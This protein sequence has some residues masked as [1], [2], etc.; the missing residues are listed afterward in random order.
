MNKFYVTT[1]IAYANAKPHIGFALEL[2]QADVLARLHRQKGENTFFLTGTDEHGTKLYRAAKEA[3]KEPQEFCDEISQQYRELKKVLN[4]SRDDFIRTTEE[5]H[6]KAAQALWKKCEKDI[7]KK[8]YKGYYCVGC[9]NFINQKDLVDGKCPNH[10]KKPELV[11]EENYFFKLSKYQDKLLDFYKE[12]PNF[13]IPEKRFNEIRS[14]VK[15]GLEDISI[16]RSKE[17]LPWGIAVP[18]DESQIMYVW[19]D[20]LTNYISALGWPEEKKEF[21]T[22]WP[23]DIHV[24]GKDINRFHTALWPAM[25][26][27]AEIDPPKQVLVHGFISSEGKKMSKSLGNVVD[28]VKLVNKYSTDAVRYYLLREIPTT[29]DGDFSQEKFKERYNHD[30]ANNLGNLLNRVLVMMKRYEIA[31]VKLKKQYSSLDELKKDYPQ[32]YIFDN[33]RYN[34]LLDDFRLDLALGEIWK[35]ITES[36]Q[37]IDKEKPWV[38]AKNDKKKLEF[39]LQNLHSRLN[40]IGCLLEPFLPETGQKIAKQL[41]SLK[42]EVLFPKIQ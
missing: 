3:N 13:V 19:F 22:F 29:E 24:I 14:F 26:M 35:I 38:L 6:K 42:P 36:N 37:L 25:L 2:I 33:K 9:E 7:Y 41:K 12:N 8:K 16:S 5:R 39:V 23:A 1:S 17:K 31:P 10:Q 21:E 11:E 4:L 27:S 28:P 18:G 15:E 30:L 40:V 32:C 34:E 20:A